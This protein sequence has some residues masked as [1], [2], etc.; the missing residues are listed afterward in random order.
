M[1]DKKLNILIAPNSFKECASSVQIVEILK[2]NLVS[3]NFNLFSFPISD[4]GDGF[5]EV[6]NHHFDLEILNFGVSTPFD[7]TKI[8][9]PVGYK[10]ESQTIFIESAKV[11][12]LN[13][14]PR[15]LRKPGKLS[16]KGM[17]DL[18]NAIQSKVE[19]GKL[20]VKKIIVGVGGSGTND[21]GIGMCSRLGLKLYDRV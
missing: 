4:G 13:L 7:E 3:E 12:G 18:I 11:L 21:L 5:L 17:G 10:K 20:E 19:S 15:E 1:A 16:S 8:I 2:A 9:V 6:C 14:I